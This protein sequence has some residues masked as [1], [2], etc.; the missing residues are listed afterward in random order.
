MP[1]LPPPKYTTCGT[2]FGALLLCGTLGVPCNARPNT[3]THPT[4][5]YHHDRIHASTPSPCPAPTR[6]CTLQH[7][8]RCCS[9]RMQVRGGVVTASSFF[10]RLLCFGIG[11]GEEEEAKSKEDEKIGWLARSKKP[12]LPSLP[13]GCG[14]K[15]LGFVLDSIGMARRRDGWM[16]VLYM[17][18]QEAVRCGAVRCGCGYDIRPAARALR[19]NHGMLRCESESWLAGCVQVHGTLAGFVFDTVQYCRNRNTAQ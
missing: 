6:S 13:A 3:P 18:G 12:A 17:Q 19:E 7:P 5:R 2:F 8:L 9:S 14:G 1:H 10:F 4:F 16:S 11:S 15:E